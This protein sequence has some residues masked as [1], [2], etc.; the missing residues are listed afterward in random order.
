MPDVST[1]PAFKAALV[2][3]LETRLPSDR[4]GLWWPGDQTEG[5][6][7]YLADVEG[8]KELASIKTGRQRRNETYRV[9]FVCQS[10][11]CAPN[12]ADL[13]AAGVAVAAHEAIVDDE[14]ANDPRCGDTVQLAQVAGFEST[15]VRFERGVA[16]RLAGVI[17]V[18]AHLS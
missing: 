4:L 10:P 1:W 17:T 13:T 15:V 6:G 12:K 8:A 7:I 16:V 11:T 9:G 2:A 3:K 14:L 18:S 5:E